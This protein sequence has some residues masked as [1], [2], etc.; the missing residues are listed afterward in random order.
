MKDYPKVIYVQ[1]ESDN[2]E[3]YLMTWNKSEDANDGEV[4]IYD[5]REVKTK[6]TKTILE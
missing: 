4:A 1:E 6:S 3:S 5:L 2:T